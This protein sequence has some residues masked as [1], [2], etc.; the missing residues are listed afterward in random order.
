MP[1]QQKSILH[2]TQEQEKLSALD[3]NHDLHHI[4]NWQTNGLVL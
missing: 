3:I 4:N 1:L 2:P